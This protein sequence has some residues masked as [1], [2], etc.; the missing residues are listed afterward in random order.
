MK[1][2]YESLT[3]VN[4]HFEHAFMDQFRVLLSK[5]WYILGD[6][7]LSFEN[8]FASYLGMNSVVGVGNGL[9]ALVLSI[10]AL[11]L[12]RNSEI[13]VP[14]NTYIATILSIIRSGHKP[15]LVEPDIL[16]YN[17][18]PNKIERAITKSTRV[19]LVVHMYGKPCEMNSILS[20]AN[21]YN[22]K[23]IED[24]AQA[25][26]AQFDGV[27]C[28]NFGDV[29]A[30]SFYPTKNLGCLGDGG[31]I[32]T[33]NYAISEKIRTLR[34]Y[35]SKTKYKNELIG[36]NSR[37]DEIQA[38]FLNIKL[39]YLDEINNHKIS[40]AKLYFDNIHNDLLI[41]P[42]INKFEKHVFHIFN[43][44]TTHR[45]KLKIY[46]E[47]NGVKT[48]VH[49]PIAPHKQLAYKNILDGKYPIT[50]EIHSTTLSLP[51]SF[52][53]TETDISYVIDVLNNYKEC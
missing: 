7:V 34:N 30:F 47:E 29:S 36:Y 6:E 45:D 40:L 15:I 27:F 25:H 46:L 48:E 51:I 1:V 21:K 43:I 41:L 42:A 49:Y 28:G 19:I 8:N 4:K 2:K 33:N 44:R 10:E 53:H 13:I 37:L 35:G 16:T 18:D 5:G 17:I 12:P 23:I 22:I 11:G 38:S 20:I 3:D 9:D 50:E 14:A 26:G 52:G 24:C 32:A 31:A 39:K